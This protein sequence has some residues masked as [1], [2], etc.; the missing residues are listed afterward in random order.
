[1]QDNKN[2]LDE[3]RVET[4]LDHDTDEGEYDDL[5]DIDL[6]QMEEQKEDYESKYKS[7]LSEHDKLR[8]AF[9]KQKKASKAQKNTSTDD[10]LDARLDARLEMRE[11]YKNN[12]DAV[13][14][15]EKIED[16]AKK[17]ISR[18]DALYLLSRNTAEAKQSAEPKTVGR[19][20]IK[21][22]FQKVTADEY[23]K[24]SEKSQ[25]NYLKASEEEYGELVFE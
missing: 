13:D 2:Q 5:D 15:K 7:L 4:D 21:T 12:P 11:F 6:L 18:D 19:P 20:R 23:L 24:M 3:E 17:G 10:D 8:K 25:V 1:M 9:V 14:L 16:Y 22:G